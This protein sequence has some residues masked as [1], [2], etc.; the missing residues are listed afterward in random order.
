[1]FRKADWKE[2]GGYFATEI[3]PAG[4]EDW[5]LW[6]TLT[7]RGRFGRLLP[8]PLFAYRRRRGSMS[9]R[10]REVLPRL[11]TE[12]RTR[13]VELYLPAAAATLRAAH[14]LRNA[15]FA[16]RYLAQP[17]PAPP[18]NRERPVFSV[19]VPVQGGEA[20]LAACLA[21]VSSQQGV[22]LELIVVDDASRDAATAET[23]ETAVASPR[24]RVLRTGTR[25]GIPRALNRALDAS[26]G[27]W[28][29]LLDADAELVPDA[30]A[31]VAECV[32]RGE[33]K[34]CIS[35]CM[36]EIDVEGRVLG[37]RPGAEGAEHLGRGHGPGHF[38][39]V[40]REALALVGPFDPSLEGCEDYDLALRCAEARPLT[41]IDRVLCRRR[42]RGPDSPRPSVPPEELAERVRRRARL[43]RFL[44]DDSVRKGDLF[45]VEVALLGR[46]AAAPALPKSF[47][48]RATRLPGDWGA[49]DAD[50]AAAAARER[51]S[52][53]ALGETDGPPWVL[54]VGA[55]TDV[56][57]VDLP[58]WIAAALS[59]GRAIAVPASP[60]RPPP[61]EGG[62]AVVPGRGVLVPREA[63]ARLR[64]PEAWRRALHAG[65]MPAVFAWG[66]HESRTGSASRSA[67]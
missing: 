51:D 54:L 58:R 50:L 6:L 20:H 22:E 36:I 26:R 48:V 49:A 66:T 15:D 10:M 2:A 39:V 1:M 33:G 25:L 32:G 52:L 65:E 37:E 14:P 64:D 13:H 67:S 4:I 53:A 5:H 28:I 45:A 62:P 40:S 23:L 31:A 46:D 29:A 34:S 57:A 30:L 59:R 21:S 19:I 3:R 63:L 11:I 55:E 7:G 47:D 24:C 43:R 38:R 61:F 27:S 41:F 44:A 17:G 56:A 18:P 42:L 16:E 60:D 12:L 9:D 35:S 8:L